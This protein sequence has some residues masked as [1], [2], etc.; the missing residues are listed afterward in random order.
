M[1]ETDQ[2]PFSSNSGFVS[3]V[4]YQTVLIVL[5]HLTDKFIQLQAPGANDLDPEVIRMLR[6][7]DVDF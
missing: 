6:G 4:T 2:T 3:M 5:R 7:R 1:K